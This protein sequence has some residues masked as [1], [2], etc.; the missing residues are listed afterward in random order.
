M[1]TTDGPT[2]GS[3]LVIGDGGAAADAP[4]HTI[5]ALELALADGADGLALGVHL[6]RDGH[7]VVMRDFSIDRTTDG[8]GAVREHTVR[9]LKRLDAGG[10]RGHQFQGQRV[11]TLQE[12]LERFRERTRF[13][14][15]LRAGSDVYPDIEERVVGMVEIYDVVD[16]ALIHSA[17]RAAL[18]RCRGFN[19]DLR[20]GT[21]GASGLPDG[22]SE[23][24]VQAVCLPAE[25]LTDA[26]TATFRR[27]GFECYAW[28]ANEP[29]EIDRLV[30]WG[31]DG[32]VTER[33]GALRRRL[34]R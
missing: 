15:E 24:P 33:P 4:E 23:A 34:A 12:V 7:P 3:P 9:E 11:Q 10:W 8:R 19:R 32:I 29:V 22:L 28:T 17:D 1:V 30:R 27:A 14:L 6:T 5:A 26:T 16:R 21:G 31:V 20:L 2:P 25:D 13:W 18:A